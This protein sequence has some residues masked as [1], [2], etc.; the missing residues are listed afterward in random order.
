MGVTAVSS[1]PVKVAPPAA[2]PDGNAGH[3]PIGGVR[4]RG[5]IAVV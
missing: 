5:G 2:A 4:R 1:T 3:I